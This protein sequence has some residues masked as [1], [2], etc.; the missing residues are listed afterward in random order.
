VLTEQLTVD[1]DLAFA[2]V[3][4]CRSWVQGL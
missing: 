3:A 1:E 4:V 2:N